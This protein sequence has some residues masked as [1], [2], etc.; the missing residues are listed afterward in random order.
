VKE[1]ILKDAENGDPYAGLGV[2][3]MYHHGKGLELDR[4]K[5]LRWYRISAEEGCTRSQWELAKLYRDGV[6][7]EADTEKYIYH[8]KKASRMGNPE[9]QMS[10]AG[11]YYKGELLPKDDEEAFR[12]MSLSAK[13]GVPTAQFNLGYMYKHG[14]G[15]ERNRTESESCFSSAVI[16]GNADLFLD[17]GMRYEFGLKG[18]SRNEVEA[19]RWYKSGADMGHEGCIL[20]WNRVMQSLSGSPKDTFESR[21]DMLA[22][23]ATAMERNERDTAFYLANDYFDKDDLYE[24]FKHFEKAADLGSP[25][26]MFFLSMMY[27]DGLYAKRNSGK[28]L[29]LLARAADAGSADAQFMLA[30]LYDSGGGLAESEVDAIKYYT[31][32]AAG[33]YLAALYYLGK[34]MEHPEIHVRRSVGKY[35]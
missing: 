23:T 4:D 26:A 30:R 11:E 2:A 35:R 14:I 24:A 7:V 12:W 8:L 10:L 16:A 5:A 19:G 3:Y 1:Q 22:R 28:S 33:G 13:Q 18:I 20:C 29:I 27:R 15:T 6:M 21:M 32:A 25:D 17:F 9:A 34:Y 31:M